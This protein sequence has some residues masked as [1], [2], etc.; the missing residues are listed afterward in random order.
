M[1]YAAAVLDASAVIAVITNEVH[2]PALIQLTEGAEL[3]SPW[4]LPIEIGNAF[5]AMFKRKRISLDQAKAAVKAYQ[6]IPIR[7][8]DIDLMR[9]LEI[10][11]DL[12]IYAYDA[13][14]IDCGLQN[15]APLLTVDKGLQDAARRAGVEVPEVVA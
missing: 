14:L 4:S 7:L 2:R 3:L 13:Y 12:G 6:Q 10:S 1:A 8:L 11:H 9:S 15:R 5:S